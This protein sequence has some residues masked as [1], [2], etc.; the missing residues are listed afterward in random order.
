M[1]Y[2]AVRVPT[3]TD[4]KVISARAY[5]AESSSSAS[6]WSGALAVVAHPYGPLGGSQDDHVVTATA[7][8]MQRENIP[9]Y[10]FDFRRPT[11]WTAERERGDFLAVVAHAVTRH[12]GVR[13]IICCGYS[14]GS[15][16]LPRASRVRDVVGE[17]VVVDYILVSPL[18]GAL[19]TSLLTL[20]LGDVYGHLATVGG[21]GAGRDEEEGEEGEVV[22][23]WGTKDQFSSSQR[24]RARWA[25]PQGR[26]VVGA[27]HFWRTR[28]SMDELQR[29]VRNFCREK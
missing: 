12:P 2:R 13:R 27:D 18:S 28:E 10:T 8:T 7:T 9:A 15:L 23:V 11:S 29:Y 24:S 1:S 21:R 17:A 20:S 4:G 22:S 16:C 19:L 14:Y 5:S 3:S 26:E 6:G 25:H